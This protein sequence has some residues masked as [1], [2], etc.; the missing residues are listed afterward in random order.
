MWK[1]YVARNELEIDDQF[2]ITALLGNDF[3]PDE[4]TEIV[5]V[6][7]FVASADSVAT[8]RASLMSTFFRN[9][10]RNV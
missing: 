4:E 3:E 5:E 7:Q 10:F 9:L 8:F 6:E 1:D 2:E